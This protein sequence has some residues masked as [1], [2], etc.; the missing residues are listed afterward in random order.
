MVT[1]DEL[2]RQTAAAL[3]PFPADLL[4]GQ[5]RRA[6]VLLWRQARRRAP[7]ELTIAQ[8]SALATVVRS[9]PIGV[10]QL[11]EA[12]ALPSPA[13]TRLA[14]RLEEAG[15]ITRRPNPADRRGVLLVAT[16]AGKKMMA[17]RE[18]ASNT[19]LAERLEALPPSDRLA[20]ERAVPALWA[21]AGEKDW[22]KD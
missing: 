9:G 6:I 13:M 18:Q 22:E 14:D 5:V 20:L 12:E 21:L 1:E 7:S 16:T 8:L 3:G 19:W 15:L 10:G 2:P 17:R 11:A 4:A